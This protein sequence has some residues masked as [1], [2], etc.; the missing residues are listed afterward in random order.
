MVVQSRILSANF[1]RGFFAN[2][3]FFS[4]NYFLIPILPFFLKNQGFN[5][6]EIGLVISVY[7]L[8]AIF[9][10]TI[11]G[12]LTSF[13]SSRNLML[14]GAIIGVIINPLYLLTGALTSLLIVRLLHGAGTATFATSSSIY[15]TEISPPDKLARSIGLYYISGNLAVG[16]APAAASLMMKKLSFPALL[17][18]SSLISLVSFLIVSRIKLPVLVCDGASS[19]PFVQLLKDHN[20]LLPSL[21]FASCS[22]TLGAIMAFLPLYVLEIPNGD[23]ATFFFIYSIVMIVT[24]VTG[25]GGLAD[26]FGR[27]W[28]IVPA[29]LAVCTQELN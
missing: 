27:A 15:V 13:Y 7:S 1:M 19:R 20:I 22:F 10:R 29:M 16:L 26:R 18:V 12:R 14:V 28:V 21:T 24:R 3:S 2:L 4:A 23:A 9:F 11:V 5:N 25:M 17:S 8:M 6:S